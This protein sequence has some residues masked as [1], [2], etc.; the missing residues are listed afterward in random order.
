M[1]FFRSLLLGRHLQ[2]NDQCL[3]DRVV[4]RLSEPGLNAR[5]EIER[6]RPNPINDLMADSCD[7][8]ALASSV[9]LIVRTVNEAL[10]FEF[11]CSSTCVGGIQAGKSR[12]LSK[13]TIAK[14]REIQ[15][16][17]PFLNAQ[18]FLVESFGPKH[19]AQS[20]NGAVHVDIDE[21]AEVYV[22]S[23]RFQHLACIPEDQVWI[24]GALDRI[25]L[26][27]NFVASATKN[28]SICYIF[29]DQQVILTHTW[30]VAA[31]RP[32]QWKDSRRSK[33]QPSHLWP[34]CQSG[35]SFQL[36]STGLPG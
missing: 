7:A 33:W 20:P 26:A 12:E 6:L 22:I 4:S 32:E 27:R 16:S 31:M 23:G 14:S 36:R 8:K 19:C 2:K 30:A 13:M 18:S 15:Q 28:C 29:L 1:N 9:V 34:L 25:G 3:L 5:V 35:H 21:R 17:A 24:K 11:Q 10:L